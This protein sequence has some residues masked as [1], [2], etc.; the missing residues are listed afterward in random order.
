MIH[1]IN[2][3]IVSFTLFG[4]DLQVRWYGLFYVL[5]FII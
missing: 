5:S 4:M 3:E 2:P 1:N